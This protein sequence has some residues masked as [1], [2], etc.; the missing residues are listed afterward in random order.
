M[1]VDPKDPLGLEGDDFYLLEPV[2][3]Q[4]GREPADSVRKQCFNALH[5]AG[6]KS[7]YVERKNAILVVGCSIDGFRFLIEPGVLCFEEWWFVN[8]VFVF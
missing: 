4:I 5:T 1:V 3:I 6:L 2:Y 7:I 8:M